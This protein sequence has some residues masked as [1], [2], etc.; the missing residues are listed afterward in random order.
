MFKTLRATLIA[1]A[2]AASGALATASPTFA[3]YY[4]QCI[5]D[6]N[7]QHA[8]LDKLNVTAGIVE[9]VADVTYER[10]THACTDSLNSWGQ[11]YVFPVNLQGGAGRAV[12]QVG[13]GSTSLH[14][15]PA[16]FVSPNDSSSAVII[17]SWP[18]PIVG[19]SYHFRI[20][21]A[22][23]AGAS[24]WVYS[25]TDNNIPATYTYCASKAASL[26]TEMWSG[27][28]VSDSNDQMGAAATPAQNIYDMGWR[29]SST[30]SYFSTTTITLG[31]CN[32]PI[33]KSYWKV[34]ASIDPDGHSI[35]SGY[36]INH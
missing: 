32:S 15:T 26:P 2:L 16:F 9:G 8:T 18:A 35:I 19:H 21:N 31:C 7:N 12:A 30:F 27:F 14:Q 29:S 6:N 17:P 13:W 36:T 4:Y 11:S 20:L 23:C 33:M 1:L 24:N 34:S 25:V 10:S 22:T 3:A 28:E 5:K